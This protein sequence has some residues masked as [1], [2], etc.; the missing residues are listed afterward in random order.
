MDVLECIHTR[1]SVRKFTEAPVEWEKVGICIE[2]AIQAPSSGNL[3][4]W[5]FVVVTDAEKRKQIGEAS[6]QQHWI[7]VAPVH[8]VVCAEPEKVEQYYGIRGE[9]LYSVQNCAAAIENFLLAA[10]AQGLSSCW[11]GAFEEEML[12]RI[13]DIPDYIRPQAIL[14]LG[15]AAEVAK[16]TPRAPLYDKVYPNSW[17]AHTADINHVFGYHSAKVQK[18]IQTGKD[19]VDGKY[20]KKIGNS[21]TKGKE[22]FKGLVKK[23]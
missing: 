14:P 15:Y 5:K 21:F 16:K 23:K 11:I 9:R 22:F 4:S 20:N 6:L 1:R 12:K 2:A 7:A 3:Q 8:V 10:H 17:G 18:A 19:F 13:L